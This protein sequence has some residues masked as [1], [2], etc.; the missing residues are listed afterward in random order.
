MRFRFSLFAILLFSITVNGQTSMFNKYVVYFKDKNNNT[1]SVNNPSAFLS[2]K[3]IDRRIKFGIDITE[4]DLPLTQ[5]YL[6]SVISTGV[7]IL[8]PS[9]WLN[10]VTIQTSDSLA[11]ISIANFPFVDTVYPVSVYPAPQVNG[12]F[13]WTQSTIHHKQQSI[14]IWN[15]Y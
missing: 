10:C 8:N 13:F 3:A 11:L 14:K 12:I 5:S 2:Q 9:K 4:K 15:G 7:K 1:C 6:D